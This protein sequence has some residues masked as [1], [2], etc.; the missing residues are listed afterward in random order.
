MSSLLFP[1]EQGERFVETLLA[2]GGWRTVD[3]ALRSRP[4]LATADLYEPSRWLARERPAELALPSASA[5]GPDW[6]P[7]LRSTLGEFDLRALLAEAVGERA[8]GTLA[9]G[10]TGGRYA[11]W[12]RGPLPAEGCDAPCVERDAFTLRLRFDSAAGAGA[13]AAALGS[14]LAATYEARRA[15][16]APGDTRCHDRL[17][18][19]RRHRRPHPRRRR[20]RDADARADGG[21]GRAA[22]GLE[23][24][25]C[26]GS[27][28]GRRRRRRGSG[29]ARG[30]GRG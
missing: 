30:R 24:R 3:R 27:A 14:W 29:R 12:R 21:A 16:A 19:R 25:R 2:D 11:L 1:Y 20:P 22:L 8:A 10:W 6:R 26:W 4:P 5:P 7:L 13:V 18:A 9:G 23:A 17:D 15:A 28:A